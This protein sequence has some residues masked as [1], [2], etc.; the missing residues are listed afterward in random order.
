MLHG[1]TFV[2]GCLLGLSLGLSPGLG[3]TQQPARERSQQQAMWQQVYSGQ[4]SPLLKRYCYDCHS[5]DTAEAGLKLSDFRTIESLQADRKRWTKVMRMVEFAAM[6]PEGS[7]QPTIKERQLM[8]RLL[9]PILF[10]IDCDLARDPG[11]VT[12]RRLNRSEYN[13]TV[14]DLLGVDFK[15]AENFPSDDVGHGF[16]NIGDVLSLP[17]LLFEKYMDAAEQIAT[18]AILLYDPQNLPQQRFESRKLRRHGSARF[19]GASRSY[20]IPSAGAVFAKYSPP[21][22]GRYRLRVEAGAQQAGTEFAKMQVELDSKTVKVF[23]VKAKPNAM[24][25]HSMEVDLEAR[26]YE[27]AAAFIND[28]YKPEAKNP[29]ERVRNLYIRAIELEGPLKLPPEAFPASHRRL[30]IAQPGEGKSVRQAAEEVLM[31]IIQRGFRRVVGKDERKPYID[32]VER[33]VAD[34]RS[35][36]RG[37]QVAISGILVSPYFLFRIEEHSDADNAQQ[38]Q[39]LSQYEVASR[40]SYFIWSSMPDDQLFS[41]ARAG[42]LSDPAIL[43]Q[44]VKRM[45]A[46]DRSQA[47][48]DNFASQW[49]NLRNLENI[50]PDPDKFGFFNE[51][52]RNDMRRETE[53]FFAAVMREDRSVLDFVTGRFSFLNERLAKHYGIKGVTGDKFRKV[54]LQDYPRAG[55]LT[56]GSILTL[57]SNPDRT[58]P[59]KRGK[60]IL[61]NI[62]GT[63]PPEPPAEVPELAAAQKASP[64]ATLKEQ[65][66]L[67]RENAS[68]AICHRQMDPL[69]LGLENFDAVGRWRE[70]D[71]G[72]LIDPQGILP[73]GDKFKS[74]LELIQVLGGRQEDFYRALAGKMLTYATGRGLQYYDRCAVDDIIKNMRKGEN[75]FSALVTEIVL[76]EPF[77]KKRGD[78]G[79]P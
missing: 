41:L 63:P 51:Q 66:A 15:P 8:V 26:E 18:A 29:Q 44:Q 49:L 46:D 9:E 24:Q 68:C 21:Y 25:M 4:V 34:D 28:Y 30:M 59:V 1:K 23:D 74:P 2:S 70:K 61:A 75:R 54:S 69:G 27:L 33:V 17:P 3:F 57:T 19:D 53:L 20:I 32:L 43:R 11:R 72:Q 50:K 79:Q 78:G 65:L 5:G 47:L 38:I 48:V 16:D 22:P 31:P 55:V 6:P 37:I 14:R 76:S 42:Q 62:L 52:L 58:S 7:P 36:G 39:S 73:N 71:E 67:H 10:T 77:R 64:T 60:W 45:L 56:Q 40:L 12:I 35:F 13:N